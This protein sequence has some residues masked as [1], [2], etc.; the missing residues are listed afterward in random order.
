MG[1]FRRKDE[2]GRYHTRLHP[3]DYLLLGIILIVLAV[4]LMAVMCGCRCPA[5][6]Q[7]EIQD[8]DSDMEFDHVDPVVMTPK[9]VKEEPKPEVRPAYM[10]FRL[11]KIGEVKLYATCY[12]QQD[13]TVEKM[14][15]YANQKYATM[16]HKSER[17]IQRSHY[18]VAI[19]PE[20]K[21]YHDEM[22]E[23]SD[24]WTHKYRFHVPGYNSSLMEDGEYDSGYFSV[25]RD[26]M[27]QRGRIDCLITTAGQYATLE[28]RLKNWKS[29]NRQCE[30]WEI[31]KYIV[32]TDGSERET[33]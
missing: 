8:I 19:N 23:L 6:R 18:T 26:R 15:K 11:E 31:K 17:R 7:A 28:Q 24:G 1:L 33:E 13:G 4:V 3:I 20:M 16:L 14:G 30:V 9:T 25:P 21:K 10:E 29:S 12:S 22:I 32:Y 5:G 27:T 2:F